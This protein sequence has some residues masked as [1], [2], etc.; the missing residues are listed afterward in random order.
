[1]ANDIYK[2]VIAFANTNGFMFV[3][4]TL[5]SNDLTSS[6]VS[7]ALTLFRCPCKVLLI[8]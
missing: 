1:M 5:F 4:P 6:I 3:K 7:T 8:S 2:E